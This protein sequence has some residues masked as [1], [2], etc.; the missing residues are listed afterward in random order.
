[1]SVLRVARLP[2]EQHSLPSPQCLDHQ[3][4]SDG[5]VLALVTCE[6]EANLGYK[7]SCIEKE[8][9]PRGF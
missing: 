3:C 5:A 4:S 9:G 2:C 6:S 8:M 7:R 1:M